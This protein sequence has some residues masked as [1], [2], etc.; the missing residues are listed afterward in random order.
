VRNG[1]YKEDFTTLD[2]ECDCYCCKNY[3]KAYL[4]H[5]VNTDEILGARMLSLHNITYL[6]NL[7]ERMREAIFE[8]RFLDFVDFFRKSP[9]YFN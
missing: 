9:A 3:T 4:R 7:M 8:D 5:L 1:Y 2:E 6:I